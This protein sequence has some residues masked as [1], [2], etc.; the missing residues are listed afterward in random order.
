MIEHIL[1]KMDDVKMQRLGNFGTT[2]EAVRQWKN[3]KKVVIHVKR[4]R[5][6]HVSSGLSELFR[7]KP[8]LRCMSIGY[9]HNILHKMSSY[10]FPDKV[11][12][13]RY[14][15][16]ELIENGGNGEVWLSIEHVDIRCN[17]VPNYFIR[18]NGAINYLIHE[19]D[20]LI[21]RQ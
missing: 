15:D 2:I 19:G 4:Y 21:I 6:I 14:V 3:L 17:N 11:K 8:C 9:H 1:Y 16:V 12:K 5:P 7:L 20:N 13:Y 18:G 10:I